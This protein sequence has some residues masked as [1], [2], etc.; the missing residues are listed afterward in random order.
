MFLP[1]TYFIV[2]R[3]E[4]YENIDYVWISEISTP[5]TFRK[6]IILWVDDKPKNN[7]VLIEQMRVSSNN[8]I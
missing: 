4:C 2:E 8:S 7:T 3:M 6:N 1:F 5:I